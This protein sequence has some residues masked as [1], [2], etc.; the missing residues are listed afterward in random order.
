M[1]VAAG[2]IVVRDQVEPVRWAVEEGRFLLRAPDTGGRF[3]LVEFTTP[4]GG[5]PPAHLHREQDETFIVTS[6]H[7]EFWLGGERHEGG[8]GTVVHGPRGLTHAFRN[9]SDAPATMLCVIT[10][11]GA[12]TMFEQLAALQGR[13]TPPAW[14]EV[15]ALA[16][17]HGVS[18]PADHP[19]SRGRRR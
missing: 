5:G 17:S 1:T 3:T 9:L 6:G 4:P 2:R 12:E 13:D 16:A 18:Y 8:V 10:P 7:Y 14:E 19:A 15:L 11:G